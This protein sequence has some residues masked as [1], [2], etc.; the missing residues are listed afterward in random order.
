MLGE[1]QQDIKILC[2]NY[3]LSIPMQEYFKGTQKNMGDRRPFERA[4][5]ISHLHISLNIL[6]E[7]HSTA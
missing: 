2:R 4:Q 5:P 7:W 3:N 1:K 6:T